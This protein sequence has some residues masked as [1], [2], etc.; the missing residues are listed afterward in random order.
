MTGVAGIREDGSDVSSKVNFAGSLIFLQYRIAL[1]FNSLS[2]P[3]VN[4]FSLPVS[5]R[6]VQEPRE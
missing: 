1:R 5:R 4:L 2:R 6:A 3:L